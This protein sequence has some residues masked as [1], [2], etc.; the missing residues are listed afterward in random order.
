LGDKKMLWPQD[1]PRVHSCWVWWRAQAPC[2][3]LFTPT[4]EVQRD[5]DL[6]RLIYCCALHYTVSNEECF[7]EWERDSWWLQSGVSP[8]QILYYNFG[9]V[10]L[11]VG[12]RVGKAKGSMCHGQGDWAGT[13]ASG[14]DIIGACKL[15]EC[16]WV[17][18]P[19]LQFL[20]PIRVNV[21]GI[22]LASHLLI[23]C[24]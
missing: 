10:M 18:G 7:N 21:M 8:L 9:L 1:H 13:R 4:G 19:A 16:I 5:L 20:S 3:I 23:G 12:Y 6:L 2:L 24:L 22:W 15:K 14:R 11:R 17:L